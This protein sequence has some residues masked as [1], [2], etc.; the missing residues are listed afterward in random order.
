MMK[1]SY[2][3]LNDLSRTY[4]NTFYLIDSKLFKNNYIEMQEAFRRYYKNTHI[5]YSYKT[6]YLP[7]LCKEVDSLG[8]YAEVVSEMELWLALKMGVNPRKIYYNGPYKK[9]DYVEKFLL[10]KGNLNIDSAYEVEFIEEISRK[11]SEK[12]FKVGIR[13]NINI[14]KEGISRFGIDTE[15]GLLYDIID[16]LDALPNV[17]VNGLHCHLPFRT[18]DSYFERMKEMKKILSQLRCHDLDYVSLGGGYMGKIEKTLADEFDF[19]PPSFSDYAEVV[20]GEFA[21]LFANKEFKPELII[22]PG[23]ALVANTM[24]LVT[25]V[26]DIKNVKG[27]Y[28]ATL[29]GSTHNM[30]PVVKGINRPIEVLENENPH[31]WYKNL[32]MAG[33]TCIERDYLYKG[34]SGELATDDFVVFNNVGSYSIVMKPPFILPDVAILD[35]ANTKLDPLNRIQTFEDVFSRYF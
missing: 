3:M 24:K 4:G 2:E 8:G 7:K 15:S 35:I 16:K 18:L 22:E 11:Y 9:F 6:N 34:Y 14:E 23:S 31:I 5:A 28:I 20:A 17:S 33:Y 27:Q 13:C 32:D 26:V 25:R 10:L 1:L 30:N 19:S 12:D 29:S 21:E